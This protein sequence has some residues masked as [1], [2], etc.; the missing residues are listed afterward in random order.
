MY[1]IDKVHDGFVTGRLL[2]VWRE[3]Q[4]ERS[5]AWGRAAVS[6]DVEM[7]I[8]QITVELS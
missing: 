7:G 2:H 6:K 4:F 3:Q 1:P 5:I 8:G